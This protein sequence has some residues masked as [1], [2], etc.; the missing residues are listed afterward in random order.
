[1]GKRVDKL[2]TRLRKGARKTA[3]ALSSLSDDQW[4]QVLYEN[5]H[6]WTVRD[7]LAH[8]LSVEEGLLRGGQ[9]IAVGGSGAPEG[10][11]YHAY[12]ASE[13]TRL[14]DRPPDQLLADLEAV[15]QV[16]IAWTAELDEADLDR[17]GHHPAL[18]EITLEEFINAIH[19]PQ[20][21]HLHDLRELLQQS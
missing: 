3:E 18:G 12:N 13:Q 9:S 19:G 2:V 17:M 14:A 21:M 7:M 6:M 20:L 5:P 8:L 1:M 16:T 10:F 11:D 15:R 4:R